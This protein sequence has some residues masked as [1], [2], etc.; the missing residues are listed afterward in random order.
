MPSIPEMG[1]MWEFWGTT[2]VQIICGQAA[3]PVAAWNTMV[4]NM[5]GAIDCLLTPAAARAAHR[6]CGRSR[7]AGPG[8]A[9][10]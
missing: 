5:Q 10:N 1:A 7:F 4:T 9:P 2:E 8:R 3:D 6:R